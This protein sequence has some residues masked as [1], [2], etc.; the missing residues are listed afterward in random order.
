MSHCLTTLHKMSRGGIYDQIKG[1]FSRYSVDMLWKV[2]HFE[3]MLYDNGQLLGLYADAYALTKNEEFK[4]VLT[5]T[6]N[7]LQEEM[8]A[9]DGGLYAAL[10]ADSEG[11]EGK[12]YCWS[13]KELLA[14]LKEDQL[15]ALKYFEVNE[16]GFWEHN[17]YIL[18]RRRSDQKW[19]NDFSWTLEELHSRLDQ[20]MEQLNGV[21]KNRIRPGLDNKR[22]TSWN[23]IALSG[24]TRVHEVLEDDDS[25]HL[26]VSIE[27]FLKKNMM[28][29]RLLSLIMY[30]LICIIRKGTRTVK[31]LSFI[32]VSLFASQWP[33]SGE[34]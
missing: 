3:K 11:E 6:L 17:K 12:Y 26:K 10:D 27:R 4:R 22:I 25:A 14:I 32:R 20:I 7:W 34:E 31:Y 15:W 33:T 13:E 30:L 5:Q 24:L 1:G 21:R 9:N 18:L 16:R 23:A 19:A 8:L 2:P 28:V 29:K